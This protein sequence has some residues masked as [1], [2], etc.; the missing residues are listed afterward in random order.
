MQKITQDKFMQAFS[1]KKFSTITI[2]GHLDLTLDISI[3]Y[4]S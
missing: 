2:N 1:N 3:T 4:F